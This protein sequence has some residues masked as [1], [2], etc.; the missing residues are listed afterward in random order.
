MTRRIRRISQIFFLVLFLYLVW[1]TAY[2]PKPGVPVDLFTRLDPLVAGASMLAARAFIPGM[3]L[4]L[5]IVGITILLGRIFCGWI[6]PLGTTLDASDKVFFRRKSRRRPIQARRLKY[7]ILA[8]L[9][10]S[11][12]F[13][14]QAVYLLDPLSLLTRTVVLAFLAPLQMAVRWLAG[15]IYSFSFGSCSVA[16]MGI[17]LN[18]RID[19]WQFLSGPQLHFRHGLVVLA[20]FVIIVGLNGLSRRF[21]CRN[22]CPL[23]ALLGL[24]SRVPVLKRVVNESCPECA[25]CTG[26]CKMAAIL[27]NP[28]L[29][30]TS[31]CIEC[32]NCVKVCPADAVHFGF[33]LKPNLRPEIGLDLS[34]RRLLIGAG[35]GMAMAATKFGKAS[36]SQARLLIRPPGSVE[37]DQF[38]AKCIRCGACMKVCPTNGLQP[39][40]REAGLEGFWTPVLVPRIGCCT[41]Q[42]N[43]CGE[44]CP[45]DAIEPFKIEDKK[46]IFIGTAVIDRKHCIAWDE[47]KK[48]LVCDEYCSYQA[49]EWKVVDGFKRPFVDKK[50]CV[51]CGICEFA[52]PIK[53]AAIIIR[54]DKGSR[55]S[56]VVRRPQKQSVWHV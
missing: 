30:R 45:T 4:S 15:A 18:D 39:A 46:H 8:A 24:L 5:V 1:I 50:K 22:L 53:P 23:G 11:A 34:R 42:C 13:G 17:W 55:P 48:C 3:M 54:A 25:K 43:A 37:E 19:A 56:P 38:A 40:L 29:T 49:V 7:Y 2:P 44:V 26:D 35:V 32:F 16:T 12:I 6:C 21:W 52:C 14:M 27:E 28:R 31:E 20:I 33:M 41:E 51:G 9:F 36:D 47:D 10:V